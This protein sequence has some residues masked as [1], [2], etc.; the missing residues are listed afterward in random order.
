MQV[1]N[2]PNK[3]GMLAG[4]KKEELEESQKRTI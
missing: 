3:L 4:K 1:Q 2:E